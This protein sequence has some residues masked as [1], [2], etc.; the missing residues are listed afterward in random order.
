MSKAG[1][2]E[3][4]AGRVIRKYHG[5]RVT[6]RGEEVSAV[7]EWRPMMLGEDGNLYQA[8]NASVYI[9]KSELTD[10]PVMDEYIITQ[11]GKTLD[12]FDVVEMPDEWECSC[13]L[14]K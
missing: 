2:M 11:G 14:H 7:V 10:A 3:A 4:L 8:G 12:I 5:E 1:D 13:R 6:I 9:P